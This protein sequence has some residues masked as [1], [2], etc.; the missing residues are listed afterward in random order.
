MQR[1]ATIFEKLQRKLDKFK[2]ANSAKGFRA[3]GK[4]QWERVKYPFKESTI[5]KLRDLLHEQKVDLTLVLESLQ[6]DTANLF[7]DR[8]DSLDQKMERLTLNLDTVNTNIQRVR[9]KLELSEKNEKSRQMLQWLCSVDPSTNHEAAQSKREPGSGMWFLEGSEFN[10][11]KVSGSVL[12][13]NGE[14]GRGKTVLC[15]AIIED[16]KSYCQVETPCQLAYF[17]F[18][19]TDPRTQSAVTCISS[20]LRQLCENRGIPE[21]LEILYD[22]KTKESR[23]EASFE[24]ITYFLELIIRDIGCVFI[25]LDALD[26]CL[27]GVDGRYRQQMIQWVYNITSSCPNVRL[28][29]TSRSD[30]SSYD[31]VEVITRHPKLVKVSIDAAKTREDMRLHLSEQFRN[32]PTLRKAQEI[33]KINISNVFLERADGMFQWVDCQLDELKSLQIVRLREVTMILSSLSSSL[34]E[35][36]MRVLRSIDSRLSTEAGN[37][38]QWLC[39]SLQPMTI[40]ALTEASIVN[41]N[42]SIV[43]NDLDRMMPEDLLKLLQGLVVTRRVRQDK[44][45]EQLELCLSHISVKEFLL[46]SGIQEGPYSESRFKEEVSHRDIAANCIAYIYYYS[47]S[48]EKTGTKEDLNSFPLLY[49]ACRFWFEHVKLA[50]EHGSTLTSKVIQLLQTLTVLED[51]LVVYNPHQPT[52]SPFSKI[53]IQRL[54]SPLG[55]AAVLGLDLVAKELLESYGGEM[56][57][58]QDESESSFHNRQKLKCEEVESLH[59]I[60]GNSLMKAVYFGHEKIVRLFIEKGASV[61]TSWGYPDSALTLACEYERENILRILLDNGANPNGYPDEDTI[62]IPLYIAAFVGNVAMG[63]LLLERGAD[64]NG[65][66]VPEITPLMHAAW[67]GN[68]GMCE[69]L[70]ESNADV[71]RVSDDCELPDALAAAASKGNVDIVQYLLSHHAI[72]TENALYY[73]LTGLEDGPRD[74]HE[75]ICKLFIAWGANVNPS[76]VEYDL[77]LTLALYNGWIDVAHLM[78]RN[79]AKIDSQDPS[80]LAAGNLL[81][82]AV[83]SG[84]VELVNLLL[85]KG[86]DVNAPTAEVSLFSHYEF[87]GPFAT[88]LQAAAHEVRI[89]VVKLLLTRGA[90]VNAFGPPYGSALGAVAAGI[91][92]RSVF[93]SSGQRLKLVQIGGSISKLLITN[94]ADMESAVRL[95]PNQRILVILKELC[96][97]NIAEVA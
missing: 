57:E 49:Y 2:D 7:V 91:F 88:P 34:D 54:A 82:A 47:S 62:S 23:H 12:W 76:V 80:C 66:P 17:Y 19:F 70:T 35:V 96:G 30:M 24:E 86:I 92:E 21:R 5:F 83:I 69:L 60:T 87:E 13:L 10:A 56:D 52:T 9:S 90:D 58:Y 22:K 40:E 18:S 55:W 84:S 63:K 78:I 44:Q 48:A 46:R 77:P 93:M 61:H 15:S 36:Y 20:L 53:V 94:K 11:W 72:I 31:I 73:S 79:G 16:L 75:A 43:V 95:C 8:L 38:L 14:I 45:D 28:S 39:H 81:Q 37:A 3:H 1:C 89:D 74:D 65:L 29:F 51:C 27:P 97:V 59:R 71:N 26:E 50:A 41:P 67:H 32:H 68:L 64:P 25:V 85:E 33:S 6:I 4:L 42:Q